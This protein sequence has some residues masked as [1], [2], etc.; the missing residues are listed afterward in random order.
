MRLDIDA[1]VDWT[2]DFS[3][4]S[5]MYEP[6]QSLSGMFSSFVDHWPGLNDYQKI[7]EAQPEPVLTR[8]GKK[9]RIVKQDNKPQGFKEHYAPRIYLKG[10]IQ[11]R[12]ENWHDF[13]NY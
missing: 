3:A 5:P 12:T 10:E 9:L 8:T 1:L 6:L 4:R 13:F 11:T 2:P 7:L